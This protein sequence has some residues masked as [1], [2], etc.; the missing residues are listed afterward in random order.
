M[1]LHDKLDQCTDRVWLEFVLKGSSALHTDNVGNYAHRPRKRGWLWSIPTVRANPHLSPICGKACEFW[2]CVPVFLLWWGQV[3]ILSVFLLPKNN[4][5]P[6]GS[7]VWKLS[8]WLMFKQCLGPRSMSRGNR[9]SECQWLWQELEAMR[10][11]AKAKNMPPRYMGKW[12]SAS[13]AEVDAE[14]EKGTPY[15][16]RFRVPQE[17]SVTIYDLIRGEVHGLLSMILWVRA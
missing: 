3:I 1:V 15:T 2:S 16:Y 8:S 5:L 10:E 17:G 14:L 12:A 11:E 4:L 7:K 13:Q 6:A 9:E